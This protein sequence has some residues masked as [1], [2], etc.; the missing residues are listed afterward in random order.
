MFTTRD[1]YT[2][3]GAD[4]FERRDPERLT[5]RLIGRLEA[6][7]NTVTLNPSRAKPSASISHRPPCIS[8]AS[9]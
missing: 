5:K 8:A 2:D 9:G 7:G 6:L 1:T 3:L 4:Y